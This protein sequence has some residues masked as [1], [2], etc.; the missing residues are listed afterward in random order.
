MT[1][2]FKPWMLPFIKMYVHLK[3]AMIRLRLKIWWMQIQTIYWKLV[4]TYYD[5][6]I[7]RLH[8]EI[9]YLKRTNHD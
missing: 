3:P 1:I 9:D 4:N 5:F 8:A 6:K 2:L 7:A